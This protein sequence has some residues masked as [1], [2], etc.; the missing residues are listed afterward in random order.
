MLILN[1]EKL[2]RLLQEMQSEVNGSVRV[3]CSIGSYL[4]SEGFIIQVQIV[5]ESSPVRFYPSIGFEDIV[6]PESEVL[7][8]S[9]VLDLGG[10]RVRLEDVDRLLAEGSL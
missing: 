2:S 9:H 5:F 7:G 6:Q 10:N 3:C 8:F 1:N 4:D